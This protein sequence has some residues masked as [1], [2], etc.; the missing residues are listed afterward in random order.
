MRDHRK[1][2]DV[3]LVVDQGYAMLN[4]ASNLGVADATPLT[5]HQ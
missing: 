2:G 4:V 3:A 1:C 5:G